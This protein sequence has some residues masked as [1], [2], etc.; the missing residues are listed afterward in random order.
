[1]SNCM[2][3][4]SVVCQLCLLF[5]LPVF[6]FVYMSTCLSVYSVECQL[7]LLFSLP[8]C[9][10]VCMSTCMSVYSVVCQL[11]LLFS[12]TVCLFVCMS[13]CLSVYSVVCKLCLLF[14]LPVCLSFCL[15]YDL[16][17]CAVAR[18]TV[19][20]I[21]TVNTTRF[22]SSMLLCLSANLHPDITID[23]REIFI[24]SVRRRNYHVNTVNMYVQ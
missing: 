16:L 15:L 4:Y 12:L 23:V 8:V 11:C 9:L 19:A 22:C 17:A 10:L 6:L 13:T 2:S 1:M 14:S 7:C 21:R 24:F 5:S 20:S 3:V 18:W